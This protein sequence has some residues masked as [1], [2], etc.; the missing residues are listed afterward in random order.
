MLMVVLS[1]LPEIKNNIDYANRTQVYPTW[2]CSLLREW[3]Q[4]FGAEV[5]RRQADEVLQDI[6]SC[7]CFWESAST[8]MKDGELLPIAVELGSLIGV[9]WTAFFSM[10]V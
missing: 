3:V 9:K 1:E 5:K 10:A 2:S 7:G 4:L 8:E 6:D